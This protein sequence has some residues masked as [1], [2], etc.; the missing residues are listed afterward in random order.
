MEAFRL[1]DRKSFHSRRYRAHAG[2]Y[3][4][5]ENASVSNPSTGPGVDAVAS[6][7]RVTF[8]RDDHGLAHHAKLAV[9]G[10]PAMSAD[11]FDDLQIGRPRIGCPA[12]RTFDHVASAAFSILFQGLLRGCN[13]VFFAQ[14][15]E[16]LSIESGR[17]C[18]ACGLSV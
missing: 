7:Y 3:R 5:G 12:M 2:D 17:S 15:D 9:V 10:F 16:R 6:G 8:H 4:R 13:Q 1:L 14:G 11:G 18:K